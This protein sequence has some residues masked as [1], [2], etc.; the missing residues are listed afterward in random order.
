MN[1]VSHNIQAAQTTPESGLAGG[2]KV[3]WI[4][5][6]ANLLLIG[7][8]IVGGIFGRSQ[9]LLADAAHS[10]SDLFSDL[11]VIFGLKM[12]RKAA[13]EDHPYG[14]G[15][16]ETLA[17]LFVGFLLLL[18]GIWIGYEAL[19]AIYQ[20]RSSTPNLLAVIVAAFSIIVKEVLYWYTIVVGRRIHSPAL[21][22]NAWHHR[23]DA[24][25]SVAVLIG[26]GAAWI[27][28]D[29]HLADAIAA[30]VVAFFLLK[31]SASLSWTAFK[32]LIDTVPE[33]GVIDRIRTCASR[34]KGVRDVHDIRAR[35]SGPNVLIELHV[36][37]DRNITVLQGHAIAKDVERCILGD[38][39]GAAKVTIHV[40]PD[41]RDLPLPNN[42]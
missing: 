35:R 7:I 18:I 37:V 28:P 5:F 12:G 1:R 17:G 19:Q 3:T 36:V 27:S 25:S 33:K 13:D 23:S 30:L 34:T 38:I 21:I 22:A 14:H 31:V 16:I 24:F 4:G 41:R 40:D 2:L 10:G 20:H 26:V 39:P 6:A 9:A 32:E 42:Q 8:K 15:R 11:V 29:W